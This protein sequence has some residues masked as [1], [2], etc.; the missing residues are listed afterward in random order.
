MFK[1]P[2][3]PNV[4]RSRNEEPASKPELGSKPEPSSKQEPTSKPEPAPHFVKPK[5]GR[6]KG[7]DLQTVFVS[8]LDFSVDDDK[9]REVFSQFGSVVDVRLV[10]N[11]KGLSKGFGYIEFADMGSTREALKND[12]MRIGERPCFISEL[13][14]KVGFKFKPDIEKNKLFVSN[15]DSEVTGDQLRD[16]FVKYGDLKDVRIVT[17]RNGHSKGCAYVEFSDE[18]GAANGLK[19]DGLLIGNK[20]V[21]VEISNPKRAGMKQAPE[22]VKTLGSSTM[23]GE[24]G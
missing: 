12:R 3:I 8:N 19:A 20:N 23:Y 16:I 22:P 17:Y 15:L 1:I 18:I 10:R 2:A 11:Y 5:D 24:S 7:N 9:L 21:K 13:N 4:K 14:K 6:D